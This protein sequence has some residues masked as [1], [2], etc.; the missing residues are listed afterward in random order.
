MLVSPMATAPP[1]S[2]KADVLDTTGSVALVAV[3]RPGSLLALKLLGALPEAR[4]FLPERFVE[5]ERDRV[6]PSRGRA[7]DLIDS[8]FFTYRSLVIF[9][10][11]GM[12]VRL[13]APCLKNKRTDPAVVVVDDAAKFAV[14]VLSGHLGGANTLAKTIAGLLGAQTV[15][16]TGSDVLGTVALDMLGREFGWQIETPDLVTQ[17]SA[18]VVNG[19]PV[20][21]FQDAGET[22]WWKKGEPMPGNLFTCASLDELVARNPQTA[23]VITDRLL[24]EHNDLPAAT[25]VYRPRSLV[26]GVGCNRGTTC[27]E[28]DRAISRA[29]ESNRLARASLRGLATIDLKRDETGLLDYADKHDLP[30]RFFSAE[31][32]SAVGGTPNPSAVVEKWIGSSGVCE[33]AAILASCGSTLLVPKTK[34][35]NVTVAVAR[36]TFMVGEG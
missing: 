23:L 12:A 4:A 21:V 3:S 19:E 22:H 26:V 1:R 32:L 17:A 18:A 34:T 28:I 29:L 2:G 10:S 8:L 35:K 24:D 13:I 16:T 20:A 27:Q 14:S 6:E 7:R 11:I 25:V 30:I 36:R 15:V 33:P 5:A 31:E 9:G